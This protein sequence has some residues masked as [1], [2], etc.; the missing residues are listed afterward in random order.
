MQTCI[1]YYLFGEIVNLYVDAKFLLRVSMHNM[2]NRILFL[3]IL[4]VCPSSCG[5]ISKWRH[6][7]F[8][9]HLVQTS[10]QFFSPTAVTKCRGKPHHRGLKYTGMGRIYDFWPKLSFV[11]E[12]VRD[13]PMIAMDGSSQSMSVPMT[14]SNR[15][16][17]KASGSFF[18]DISMLETC[19]GF[20]NPAH[21]YLCNLSPTHP[22]TAICWNFFPT[23]SQNPCWLVQP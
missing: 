11:W 3:P 5:I 21:P 7:A 23:S 6:I 18:P 15:E 10:F 20:P 1:L 19:M 16:R 13:S 9:H 12:I 22:N 17:W 8:F 14:S 4:S 2:Q